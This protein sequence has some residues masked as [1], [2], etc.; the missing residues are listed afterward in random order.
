MKIHDLEKTARI[1]LEHI[2]NISGGDKDRLLFKLAGF[3]GT[4]LEVV[5]E[6]ERFD[7]LLIKATKK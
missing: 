2:I 6:K 1:H 7:E 4:L 5:K 3:Y